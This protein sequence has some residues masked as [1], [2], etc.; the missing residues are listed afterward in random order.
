M[1]LAKKD[2]GTL[3]SIASGHISGVDGIVNSIL[4]ECDAEEIKKIEEAQTSRLEMADTNYHN[5]QK[6]LRIIGEFA[7]SG[8]LRPPEVT[9]LDNVIPIGHIRQPA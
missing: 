3:L 9:P 5:A 2:S 4:R 8:E 7:T 6:T 1:I